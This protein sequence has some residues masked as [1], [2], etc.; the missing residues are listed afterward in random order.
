MA[1][2]LVIRDVFN[3]LISF[4]NLPDRFNL[5]ETKLFNFDFRLFNGLHRYA[6]LASLSKGNSA[7]RKGGG[8]I[9]LS[10]RVSF[11]GERGTVSTQAL[12]FLFRF[13]LIKIESAAHCGVLLPKE[14]DTLYIFG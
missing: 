6:A 4:V 2:P 3:N 8:G 7:Q 12:D 10:D 11:D 13:G 14:F 9:Q 5:I 1:P